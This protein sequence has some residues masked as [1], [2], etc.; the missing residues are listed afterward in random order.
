MREEPSL[1]AGVSRG[2]RCKRG[3]VGHGGSSRV[4]V[5]QAVRSVPRKSEF[6]KLALAGGEGARGVEVD[7][8]ARSADAAIAKR[9]ERGRRTSLHL[10]DSMAQCATP[11]TRHERRRAHGA[12]LRSQALGL[13]QRSSRAVGGGQGGARLAA[14]QPQG[15]ARH[16]LPVPV[17]FKV[18]I[19]CEVDE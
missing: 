16:G 8:E 4:E 7:Q 1:G 5:H 10:H 19:T 13:H 11:R 18:Y 6:G 3:K 12:F 9:I 15:Q 14:A 2:C 17:G